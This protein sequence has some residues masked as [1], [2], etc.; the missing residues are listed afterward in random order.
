[1]RFNFRRSWLKP[2]SHR[3]SVPPLNNE[4]VRVPNTKL[5]ILVILIIALNLGHDIDHT[6][7]DDF[8]WQLTAESAPVFI[9]MP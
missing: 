6:I 4:E 1:M 8:R 7:R 5:T 2:R 3:R 9:I